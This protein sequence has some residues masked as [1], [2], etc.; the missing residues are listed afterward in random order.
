MPDLIETQTELD[1]ACSNASRGNR[2]PIVRNE[3]GLRGALRHRH[4]KAIQGHGHQTIEPDEID[5][6]RNA[7]LTKCRPRLALDELRKD[8]A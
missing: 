6:F 7:V 8:A 2:R 3:S 4:V 1:R 5:Q